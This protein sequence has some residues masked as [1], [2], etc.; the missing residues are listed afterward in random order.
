MNSRGP[1]AEHPAG[2]RPPESAPTLPRWLSLM[3]RMADPLSIAA[4]FIFLLNQSWLRW[5][6]PLI[7]FPRSLYVAWRLSE[8][9]LLY[10]QV[11]SWYGPLPH[12]VEAAAFRLFGVGLDTMVWLNIAITVVAL[13][14]LRAIFGALGNRLTAWL[15][16]VVFLCVFAFGNY[17]LIA[18]YNFI[19]PYAS[20]ATYGFTGLLLVIWALLRHLKS[21]RPLW[22]GIAGWGFGIAYLDKPEPMLAS[23][24]ALGIYFAVG[25]IRRARQA[26]PSSDWWGAG[27]WA[28]RVLSWLAGGFLCAWLPVLLFFSAGVAWPMRC[29]RRIMCRS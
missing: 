13:L 15:C 26:A 19:T 22:L 11:V 23:A 29:T 20:Q 28:M 25:V 4:L 2:A 27:R 3:L 14:L 24:G 16:V 9:D 17:T 18:N 5:M 10:D 1:S 7:D 12:L 6:D 21:E 8:G